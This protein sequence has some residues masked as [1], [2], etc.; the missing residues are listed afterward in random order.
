MVAQAVLSLGAQAGYAVVIDTGQAHCQ[1]QET[2]C[3]LPRL[4]T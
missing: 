1:D 3:L 2:I 4:Y